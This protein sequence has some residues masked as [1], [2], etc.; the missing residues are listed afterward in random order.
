MAA[1]RIGDMDCVEQKFAVGN[2]DVES[3]AGT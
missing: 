2:G 1:E 3:I